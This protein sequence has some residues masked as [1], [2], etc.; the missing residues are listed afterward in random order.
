MDAQ[1]SKHLLSKTGWLEAPGCRGSFDRR[2]ANEQSMLVL[3]RGA[4][5]LMQKGQVMKDDAPSF[6]SR[7]LWNGHDA[8]IKRYNHRSLWHSLRHTIRGSRARRNWLCARH[9]LD[10]EI[11]TPQPLAY[12]DEYKGPI[13]WRSYF[14]ARFVAGRLVHHILRDE[15]VSASE[16]QRI[17]DEVL[18]LLRIMA[19]H[20]VSHG[21]MKHA[22]ILYDGTGVVLTDLDAMRIG[23]LRLLR[24]RRCRRDVAR[25]LR[26]LQGLTTTSTPS[27]GTR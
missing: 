22:N 12:W 7:V 16:K 26:D 24:R 27:Q 9:L 8:V 19:E 1:D 21:D 23:G 11:T 25:Y 15:D 4:D 6:I 20:G 17:S 10:L 2:F 18:T 13:L 14:V 5:T 3:V